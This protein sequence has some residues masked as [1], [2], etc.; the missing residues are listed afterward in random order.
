MRLLL[1]FALLLSACATSSVSSDL[2]SIGN[3]VAARSALP[4]LS[5]PGYD[6]SEAVP[7][8]ADR[9]L[10]KPLS[11]ETAVRVALLNNR[12]ARAALAEVGV[13]RGDLLQA[14]LI[15]NPE[16]EF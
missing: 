2:A 7:E 1:P 11:A 13:A 3:T 4:H 6:A 8:E 5:I 9:L 16:A 14:G 10:E 12:E 15:P